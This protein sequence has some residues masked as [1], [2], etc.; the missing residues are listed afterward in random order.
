MTQTEHLFFIQDSYF[1]HKHLYHQFSTKYQIHPLPQV[2]NSSSIQQLDLSLHRNL[3]VASWWQIFRRRLLIVNL[4]MFHRAIFQRC[5]ILQ[6]YLWLHIVVRSL[7][8]RMGV[9]MLLMGMG[10]NR[11]NGIGQRDYFQGLNYLDA[12]VG[13]T[14]WNRF[15]NWFHLDSSL[16][17]VLQRWDMLEVGHAMR[18]GLVKQF[19]Y[20]GGNCRKKIDIK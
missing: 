2:S 4:R 19:T 7:V 17:H 14:E 11:R 18:I 9:T 10:S 3:T 12:F 13:Q 8:I 5:S 16:E 1:S 20:V 15:R 6:L